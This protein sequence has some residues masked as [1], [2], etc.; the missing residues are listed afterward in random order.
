MPD[1]NTRRTLDPKR[2]TRSRNPD[3]TLWF[4]QGDQPV[5]IAQIVR[6]FPFT[7]PHIWISLR[8]LDGAEIG[9][10]NTLDG[11]EPASRRLIEEILKARYYIPKIH[12][13]TAVESG[14]GGATWAVETEDGPAQFRIL[15]DRGVDTSTFPRV[16]LTDGATRQRFEISDY[17][18]LDRPSQVLARSHLPI[19]TRGGR[20]GGFR[21]H[22][23]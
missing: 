13:I 12:R 5:Q 16:L 19:S 8:D 11:L 14:S 22:H 21:H 4:N 2:V 3:D 6:C 7:S 9:L 10:L 23:R 17:T 1:L 20:R 18:A 15:G